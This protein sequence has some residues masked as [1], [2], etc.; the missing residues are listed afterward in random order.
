MRCLNISMEHFFRRI[1]WCCH[2][3]VLL[4]LLNFSLEACS[5]EASAERD[6]FAS[7]TI[8]PYLQPR[9]VPCEYPMAEADPWKWDCKVILFHFKWNFRVL[10]S[11]IPGKPQWVLALLLNIA[12]A[13][14]GSLSVLTKHQPQIRAAQ[15]QQSFR[16]FCLQKPSSLRFIQT[17]LFAQ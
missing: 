8:F 2:T 13:P 16:T 14:K 15:T 6:E 5:Y 3:H 11:H 1:K 10:P 12:A 9:R 17:K 4:I 7:M